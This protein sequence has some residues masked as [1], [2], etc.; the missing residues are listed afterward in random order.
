[1]VINCLTSILLYLWYM[2]SVFYSLSSKLFV[3][4]F[5]SSLYLHLTTLYHITS[6]VVFCSSTIHS[7]KQNMTGF[8]FFFYFF[9]SILLIWRAWTYKRHN[10]FNGPKNTRKTK[11]RPL[12]CFYNDLCV[13]FII[14][15]SFTENM[16]CYR[17]VEIFYIVLLK[18]IL[19]NKRIKPGRLLF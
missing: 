14:F 9:G 2:T 17:F 15:N 4:L 12:P 19:I 13:R 8:F 6:H 7:V 3:F 1:M 16:I 10:S 5:F 18:L 11:T